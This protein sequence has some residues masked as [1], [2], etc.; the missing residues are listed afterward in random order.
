MTKQSSKWGDETHQR[1]AN[2]IKAARK[3]KYTAE[4]IA[5]QCAELR[6]PIS[7]GMLANLETGRL[8]NI[9][10]ADL[11]AVAMALGV[12]PISLLY[13]GMPDEVVDLMPDQPCHNYQA[14]AWFTGSEDLGW[15]EPADVTDL[16]KARELAA[17]VVG[18]PDA[19]PTRILRLMYER[20]NLRRHLA[21]V[22]SG[23]ASARN[24]VPASD[25]GRFNREV[26]E[27]ATVETLKRLAEIDA[28]LTELEQEL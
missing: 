5:E 13:P 20:Q 22:S 11:L 16:D 15:P 3:G 26:V 4:Q 21:A 8:R 2:A 10:V 27:P 7:R 14:I 17:G 25:Q 6:H 19:L 28:A 18:D 12:P 1:I 9:T 24:Y 23:L